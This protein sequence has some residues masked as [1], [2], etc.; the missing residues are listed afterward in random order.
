MRALFLAAAGYGLVWVGYFL[1]DALTPRRA[2]PW[3]WDRTSTQA[4]CSL[5]FAWLL[6]VHVLAC[7]AAAH[8]AG[9]TR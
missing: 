6:L 2:W 8:L 5:Q 9:L 7:L 4:G 1:V 3:F